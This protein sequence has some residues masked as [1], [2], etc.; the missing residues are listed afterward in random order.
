MTH[1]VLP[2]TLS[3]LGSLLSQ[4]KN[5]MYNNKKSQNTVLLTIEQN[6][7]YVFILLFNTKPTLLWSR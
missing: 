7:L 2:L 6:M 5:N 1:I 3:V 4:Y